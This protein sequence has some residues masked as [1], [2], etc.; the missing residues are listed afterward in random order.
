MDWNPL[1][2]LSVYLCVTVAYDYSG[3]CGKR[4]DNSCLKCCNNYHLVGDTCKECQP[5]LWGNNYSIKCQYP[6]LGRKCIQKC[7]CDED[8]CSAVKGC[9]KS[10]FPV[11]TFTPSINAGRQISIRRNHTRQVNFL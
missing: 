3:C 9:L 6:Y 11:A 8:I 2:V 10:T 7:E 4:I 1:I 5:G